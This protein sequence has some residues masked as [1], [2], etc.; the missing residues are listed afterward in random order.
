MGP[1]T[2]LTCAGFTV[3]CLLLSD[4]LDAGEPAVTLHGYC[5]GIQDGQ[6][7]IYFSSVFSASRDMPPVLNEVDANRPTT[8][9]WAQAFNAYLIQNHGF[10]GTA[11]CQAFAKLVDA[12]A[13][14]ER[15]LSIQRNVAPG[16]FAE[17]SWTY[18]PS[19]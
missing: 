13:N 15:Q 3:C 19:N 8:D 1:R 2:R 17:T 10:K 7:D 18:Q 4:P 14:W 6:I 9:H 11:R 16:R 12:Q 5:V